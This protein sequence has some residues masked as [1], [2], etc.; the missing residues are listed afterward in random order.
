[1]S[2]EQSN[3]ASPRPHAPE[4]RSAADQQQVVERGRRKQHRGR[5]GR[6]RGGRQGGISRDR[7]DTNTPG[8]DLVKQDISITTTS[9]ST[10]TTS[11]A[12]QFCSTMPALPLRIIKM[13]FSFAAFDD[14]NLHELSRRPLMGRCAFP[15]LVTLGS[16]NSWARAHTTELLEEVVVIHSI[17][18]A[19]AF[20][21]GSD[22][23]AS[24]RH[25]RVIVIDAILNELS[26][27][28]LEDVLRA[29][30]NVEQLVIS[31]LAGHSVGAE[32]FELESLSSKCRWNLAC[33]V[34]RLMGSL[35]VADLKALFLSVMTHDTCRV[36]RTP[37]PGH[38]QRSR[39]LKLHFVLDRL[40]LEGVWDRSILDSA[41]YAALLANTR[42]SIEVTVHPGQSALTRAQDISPI[43]PSGSFKQRSMPVQ[44][45]SIRPHGSD[46]STI[47]SLAP[48]LIK[49]RNL[50][51]INTTVTG[52]ELGVLL[53]HLPVKAPLK[54]L[55]LTVGEHDECHRVKYDY[56]NVLTLLRTR[57]LLSS[58]KKLSLPSCGPESDKR[59]IIASCKIRKIELVWNEV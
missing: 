27:F 6:G 49:C 12:T 11:S 28:V 46:N 57:R 51:S 15:F 41:L 40:Y 48:F 16:V 34:Q 4:T 19:E 30:T 39:S 55:E 24:A 22:K 58:L 38:T 50:R 53:D 17:P 44:Q 26:A 25:A 20:I 52:L 59:G 23:G 56:D 18:E 47:A 35:S 29:A 45:L 5:R 8:D 31:T 32:M 42:N 2:A 13:I 36:C 1:M 3:S 14:A 43:F 33:P 10:V 54:T 21:H 9:T 37:S 7:P